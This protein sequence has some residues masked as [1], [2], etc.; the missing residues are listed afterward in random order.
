MSWFKRK[1]D[2]IQTETKK[3]MPEGV[4]IK[5]PTTG[6]TIHKRELEDNLYVDPL[7]GYHFR[8]GSKEYFSILFDIGKFKD[9]GA[10]I[11][12]TDPLD[13]ED[14]KKYKDR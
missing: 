11:M 8:I 10:D 5:V 7:S 1:D 14:R 12:P 2:N 4:W 9:I 3:E 13:F 6:E